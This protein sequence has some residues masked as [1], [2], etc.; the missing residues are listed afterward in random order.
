[1]KILIATDGTESAIEAARKALEL[2]RDG[3]DIVLA[4]VVQDYE[5]P[6]EISGGFEGPLLT[7]EEA[8]ADY[9]QQITQGQQALERTQ[10]ALGRKVDLRLIPA[11][12]DPGHAIVK[13]ANEL[14]PDLLVLG[15][16]E[17]GFFLRLLAGS[18][19]DYVVHHATCPV[20]VVPHH[21]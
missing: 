17:K 1:M 6:L 4:T 7:A 16:A 13:L 18:V 12:D 8:E 11:S 2:L 9:R 5:D 10:T 20:L 15:S 19:S 3:I 21:H 14:N